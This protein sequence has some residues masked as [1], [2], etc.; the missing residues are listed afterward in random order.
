VLAWLF[1]STL[2]THLPILVL[3]GLNPNCAFSGGDSHQYHVL[4]TSLL[5]RGIFSV[6]TSPPYELDIF[7]TP[8]Y[9]LLMAVIYGVSGCS[10]LALAVV[11]ALL[12]ACTTVLLAS[13]T[14]RLRRSRAIAV[15]AAVV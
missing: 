9:P 8:G 3:V 6:Q 15:T 14:Y 5:D 12:T 7:R 10:L 13:L 11:Q 1:A 4:A 2:L